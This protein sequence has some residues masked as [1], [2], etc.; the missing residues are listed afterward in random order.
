MEAMERGINMLIQHDKDT[1]AAEVEQRLDKTHMAWERQFQQARL[2]LERARLE[3]EMKRQEA[4]DR[5]ARD[6]Q[7]FMVQILQVLRPAMPQYG[8]STS[9]AQYQHPAQHYYPSDPFAFPPG[10][11]SHQ[12]LSISVV[13]DQRSLSDQRNDH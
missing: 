1:T 8:P 11:A 4:E 9:F 7:Q 12:N 10:E 5:R 13:Q 2:D 3:F 6:T